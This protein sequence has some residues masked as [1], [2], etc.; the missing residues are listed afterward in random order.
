MT[1]ISTTF[2]NRPKFDHKINYYVTDDLAPNTYTR[3][4]SVG[5]SILGSFKVHSY[6]T[7]PLK[8][9]A[10]P[11]QRVSTYEEYAAG[12][13]Q[14]DRC[15]GHFC[16]TPRGTILLPQKMISTLGIMS[17]D[18]AKMAEAVFNRD[19]PS[20]EANY[21]EKARSLMLGKTGKMRGDMVAGV[22]DSSAREVINGCWE[23]PGFFCV[24]RMVAKNMR[25]LRTKR[26]E[27][28][29][30][31]IGSY[32]EDCL[33]EGDKVIV[34]R[35]PSLW[36]GNV[37]PMTVLL[38]EHECF[39][40]VTSHT[41]EYHADFDG[42]EMQMYFIDKEESLQECKQW[43]QLTPCKFYKAVQTFKLPDSY[44]KFVSTNERTY[45]K[46][47]ASKYVPEAYSQLR[48]RFM[49][50]STLSVKELL[51]GVKLP[52]TAKAARVKE[53]MADMFVIRL[54]NPSKVFKDFSNES[55]RGIRDVMA[56]Q[57]NQGYL[58]DMSRQARL[59]ASC[60]KYKGHG[61]FHILSSN[62]TIK[63]LCPPLQD[64]QRDIAYPLGGN[65]CMRA[66]SKICAVA[67]QAAL[68]SHRVSQTIASKLD[69][70][71]NFIVGGKESLIAVHKERI[72]PNSWSYQNNNIV[73]CIVE[74]ERVKSYAMGIIAA[75]HP[76][77]LKC[78][79]M[80]NGDVRTV[81][82]NG[83]TMICN[84]HNIELSVLELYSLTELLCYRCEISPDTKMIKGKQVLPDP[85]TT[86]GGILNRDM[87]WMVAVFVNHYGKLKTLQL[88]NKTTRPV[89][90]QT[91]T[92]AVSFCNFCYM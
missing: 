17:N 67:Q 63:V 37:Q 31:L 77:I 52:D 58:G 38:W 80:V 75:Y 74:N 65:S 62:E 22:V 46:Y 26:D 40:L 11:V 92:E 61:V 71:N 28:T 88:N 14:H 68:D 41:D 70:I 8:D 60:I 4:V 13:T 44:T 21:R 86:K 56:Q 82:R 79:R 85:I 6:Y 3:T 45:P 32:I 55:L 54:N 43:K 83:I 15:I 2:S 20:Q 42:D 39:G 24:P 12:C 69:L 23:E 49:V 76:T 30:L 81:C 35:P 19:T 34:I 10:I 91:I 7:E 90:P 78:I 9:R 18:Y 73:Y 1:S 29:G 47:I 5:Q 64:I 33:R 89:K 51:D 66:I 84:Y 27:E 25:V 16:V 87:R 59:S 36:A 57:L 53:P 72:P 50:S 48:K